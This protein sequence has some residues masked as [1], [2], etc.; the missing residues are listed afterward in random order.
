MTLLPAPTSWL[1]H[2]APA[3]LRLPHNCGRI[4]YLKR[5]IHS[6]ALLAQTGPP[7]P[8]WSWKEL[9]TWLTA[10]QQQLNGTHLLL[11][12]FQDA[13]CLQ[14]EKRL[15]NLED[16]CDGCCQPFSMEQLQDS[17]SWTTL[18][19]LKMVR[20]GTKWNMVWNNFQCGKQYHL[21]VDFGSLSAI[22][23]MLP[24][25]IIFCKRLENILEYGWSNSK[26]LLNL[27]VIK[28]RLAWI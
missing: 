14:Y 19:H 17:L 3:S 18:S 15:L 7:K 9:G 21:R 16:S 27:L 24:I 5:S 13:L 4:V 10:M 8:P 6:G 2:T 1:R 26:M 22:N 12:E 25:F 23:S 11:Q 20:K 28:T